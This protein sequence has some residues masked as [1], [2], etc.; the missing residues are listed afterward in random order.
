MKKFYY[1]SEKRLKFVEIER[2]N[3]KVSVILLSSILILSTLVFSVVYFTTDFFNPEREIAKLK[4]ENKNLKENLLSLSDKYSSF[5][6]DL[7]E[8]SLLSDELRLAVNLRSLTNEEKQ[9][10]VGGSSLEKSLE[11]LQTKDVKVGD[12]IKFVDDIS[13]KF[14]FEKTQYS[15][16]KDQISKNEDFFASI[17]AIIPTF[18]NY[19]RGS[20][21]M[22]LHPILKRMKMHNGIDINTDRGTTVYAPG[23]GRVLQVGKNGGYGLSVE[24]DHGFGYTTIYGH[25]SKSKVKVGQKVKRGDVIALTGNSGLSSGPHLHYEVIHNGVAQDPY[26]FFFEDFNYF[27]NKLKN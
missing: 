11:F 5:V 23:N 10:G 26:E 7:E 6:S 18:G 21:G 3:L 4:N 8:L 2:F 13:R 27:D 22:R 12:A 25:L 24:I 9:L 15:K 20:F 16:I 1:F 17:P 19:D 14:S